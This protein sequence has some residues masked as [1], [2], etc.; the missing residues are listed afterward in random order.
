MNWIDF[1]RGLG[2]I[3]IILVIAGLVAYIGDRVGHQVGRRRLTLFGIRPRYTSTIIAVATGV[4]IALVVTLIAILASQQV[5][6]ALFR[7]SALNAEITTLTQ[8]EQQLRQKVAYGRLVVPTQSLMTPLRLVLEQS[9]SRAQQEQDLRA[10][11]RDVVRYINTNLKVNYPGLKAYRVPSDADA[12]LHDFLNRPLLQALLARSNVVLITIAD[13]NLYVNDPVHFAIAPVPDVRTFA[14]GQLITGLK[15]PGASGA[16]IASAIGQLEA[17]VMEKAVY[18]G[19]PPQL[20]AI[21]EPTEFVPSSLPEME[22]MLQSAG[23]YYLVA[24]A[25]QDIYPHIGGIYI[26]IALVPQK[27]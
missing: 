19:M 11:F 6:T 12:R 17:R 8:Q 21:V 9:Q 13:Q 5:K 22:S 7:L 14:R 10:F 18:A 16:N 20:A 26:Q 4:V 25:S 27:P 3:F 2:N 23:S 1:I 15:I 24:Y